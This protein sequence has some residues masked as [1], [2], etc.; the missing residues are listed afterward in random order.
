[1]LQAVC[2]DENTCTV[3]QEGEENTENWRMR[4]KTPIEGRIPIK[5]R[6]KL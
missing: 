2:E 1:M 6:I 3:R 4:R 5:T